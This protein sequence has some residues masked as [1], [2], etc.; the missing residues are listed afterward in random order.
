MRYFCGFRAGSDA[1]DERGDR[2]GVGQQRLARGM[3][4]LFGVTPFF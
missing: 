3:M 4:L 1:C 2:L